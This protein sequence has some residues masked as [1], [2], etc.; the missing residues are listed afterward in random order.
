[1]KLWTIFSKGS[2]IELEH[3]LVF[4]TTIFCVCV[5]VKKPLDILCQL[6][7]IIASFQYTINQGFCF[8][9]I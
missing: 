2:D 6:N 3:C 1:M 8:E 7:A 4:Q 9:E 5:F